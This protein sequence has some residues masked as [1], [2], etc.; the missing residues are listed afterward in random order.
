MRRTNTSDVTKRIKPHLRARFRVWTSFW[1]PL[2]SLNVK[3]AVEWEVFL[4]RF[5]I[6]TR[7]LFRHFSKMISATVI[8]KC[9]TILVCPMD[10][11]L[12]SAYCGCSQ[13]Q[14]GPR[15]DTNFGVPV[16]W[17]KSRPPPQVFSST[18]SVAIP[19]DFNSQLCSYLFNAVCWLCGWRRS[20]SMPVRDA[21]SGVI[22]SLLQGETSI[23]PGTPV[24]TKRGRWQQSDIGVGKEEDKRRNAWTATIRVMGSSKRMRFEIQ[25][26]GDFTNRSVFDSTCPAQ[27]NRKYV[28]LIA[29]RALGSHSSVVKSNH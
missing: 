17:S 14:H 25:I 22:G 8:R 19:D 20:A 15:H 18:S 16:Q 21:I 13:H 1:A 23:H 2:P 4:G 24:V 11:M 28:C 6:E 7:P 26:G 10:G 3:Y 12:P 27:A 9:K 29:A 5:D